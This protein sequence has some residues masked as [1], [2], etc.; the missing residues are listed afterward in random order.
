V[1][2]A[3]LDMRMLFNTRVPFGTALPKLPRP[4]GRAAA[5]TAVETGKP[6][7][8]DSFLG[9]V[10]QEPLIAIA[11]P[12]LRDDKVAFLLLTTFEVRQFQDR[13]E[14][15]ILPA[16][17]SLT[18]LDGNGAVMA[19]RAPP[20]FNA[21]TDV[22]SAGRFVAQSTV[23][24][25]SVVLEI[26]RD[27]YRAPLV[28]AAIELLIA[29]AGATL[30]GVIGGLLAS[31][32]LGRWV[33]S[34]AEAPVPGNQPPVIKEIANARALLD[35]TTRQRETAEATIKDSERKLDTILGTLQEVVWS[36]N[37]QN[38]RLV[39]INAAVRML[40]R[41]SVV[42]FLAQP[43]LWRQLIHR[44]DRV[45]VRRSIRRLL[46][47]DKL[48]HEFRLVLADGEERTVEASARV[49][50]DDARR[51]VRIDG[52]VIDITERKR[53]EMAL[54]ESERFVRSTID[55]LTQSLCV[56]DEAGNIIAVNAAW[57]NF[58]EA[59]S[60]APRNVA[61]GVNYLEVCDSARGEHGVEGPAF[62]KGIR[63][64]MAGESAEF[65]MEYPCHSPNEQR[66]FVGRVTR[67]QGEGARRI[68]IT[69][70]NITARKLAE[71]AL[72]ESN[73]QLEGKVAA[74]TVDL[75]RAKH[76]AEEANRAKSSF[77][78]A[79]SH[80]I[81]TPMNGVIGMVDVLH[82]SSLRPDQVEMVE[83]IRE[84]AFSLLGI[85]NDILDF[86]KIEAGKLELEHDS[87]A[88]AEV[89]SRVCGLLK[90]MADKKG[91][92]LTFASDPAVPAWVVGDTLRLR[93]VLINLVNNAIKFSAGQPHKGQVS[94]RTSLVAQNPEQLMVEFQVSDNGIGM[95]AETQ[96]RLF[97]AFTQADASTTRRFGGTGLGLAI[98]SHLVKLMGG[99]IS[100]QSA[101]GKGS[102]FKVRLPFASAKPGEGGAAAGADSR[103][104]PDAEDMKSSTA[105]PAVAPSREEAL[106]QGRLIL[107]A[108]DNETNQK[109]IVRQLAILGYA[110]DVAA[111]GR[112]ALTRWR[113]GEYALLFTDLQMPNM[114]GYEL[115]QA[116]RAEEKGGKRIPIIALT[117]N[118]LKG[119]ADHC[120]AVGMDDYRSKPSPLAELKAVLDKRL[121][122]ATAAK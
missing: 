119:E 79:M 47:D 5:P 34:L 91:V 114:D 99:E 84:S 12:G 80:E 109:V 88:L 58:A 43:L 107:V 25:W 2:F 42:D 77:L 118:A 74:R 46:R 45:S 48:T 3:D 22:D 35:R 21:A 17:W 116:I 117:A 75:E 65:A 120:R 39:Y 94:V 70:D 60:A 102:V 89:V 67:F 28:K 1:I 62:A 72:R 95:D 73:E 113:T 32:R 40:T 56:L 11:V 82:Q 69:H 63:D 4:K 71:M 103:G 8:S 115:A 16:G 64:V 23:S 85:I 51:A 20:G 24:P 54:L 66:W 104:D 26:P 105:K 14:H 81:R 97:T 7:V 87:V 53:A 30:I 15:V 27:I 49:H 9:P 101:P 36:I 10:A 37:P 92:E 6:A 44:D 31:R 121:P 13:M 50:R 57:R 111:D 90:G 41:R 108:E 106:R 55:A 86:S 93:Q 61:V 96:A 29:I 98:S 122:P 112:E 59:N 18:L 110:A 38:R 19:Q 68:V 33:A 83:L 78:A 52:G 100:V 76:E